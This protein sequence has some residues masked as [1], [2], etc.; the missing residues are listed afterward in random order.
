MKPSTPLDTILRIIRKAIP[1]RL[2]SF[3]Q[4]FYHYALALLGALIYRFPS[5]NIFIIAITGTKGKTSTVELVNAMLEEAGYTTALS[6]TLRFKVGAESENNVYKMTLPGRFFLQKFLR[7]AVNA[8]CQYAIIELTSE[9]AR[10]YRHRFVSL[11]ALIFTNIA[12]E[13]IESHGSFEN[14]LS[15]KLS[16]AEALASSKKPRRMIIAN[17]DDS[18]GKDFLQAQVPEKYP[19]RLS[20]AEP[21]ELK[22]RSLSITLD[23]THIESPLSG[24]FNIYN[25]LAASTFAKQVGVSVETIKKALEKFKGIPGRMEYVDEGQDFTVVVDYAHTPDSLE[26]VYETFQEA[27]KICVL[28][29]TGGGRDRW[30]RK[31]MGIIANAHCSHIILTDE[32]PYDENPYTII[33]DILEGIDSPIVETIIDREEAIAKALGMAKTGDAVLITGKGTDP[34][35]MGPSGSRT[36]WSDVRVVKNKLHTIL[37]K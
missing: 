34:Y 35:I 13:H 2:F 19:F 23:N 11:D 24:T 27:Q 18:H 12:P 31:E 26:K 33:D 36:P 1:R 14:Y 16:I 7:G 32:D 8:K 37:N 21:F 25:I 6:S 29:G 20:D 4:P 5:K 28:G 22:K 10:L 15:A 3:A 30:K 17:A 9:G